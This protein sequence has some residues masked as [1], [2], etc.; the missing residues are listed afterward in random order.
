[1]NFGLW[2]RDQLAT[3]AAARRGEEQG[4]TGRRRIYVSD[5]EALALVILCVE[6]Q[7]QSVPETYTSDIARR[8]AAAL[9]ARLRA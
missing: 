8:L 7:G 9:V 1:M 2:L 4:G 3:E 6:R 5:L